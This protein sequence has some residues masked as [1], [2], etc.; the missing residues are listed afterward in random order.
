MLRVITPKGTDWAQCHYAQC[1]YAE[2]HFVDF[3]YKEC[4]GAIEN[5]SKFLFFPFSKE[6][7]DLHLMRCFYRI[8]NYC[9]LSEI[10]SKGQRFR[11]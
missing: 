1:N 4:H 5:I 6:D 2:Y 7:F 10:A 8:R 11:K 3:Q 9:N